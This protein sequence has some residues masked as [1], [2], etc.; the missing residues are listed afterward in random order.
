MNKR[1]II[2]LVPTA[3]DKAI[4]A[5]GWALLALLWVFTV[6]AY[7]NMPDII[8]AH[9]D[10]NGEVNARG[11]KST[12][13][14]IPILASVTFLMLTL[15]NKYPHLFNYTVQITEENAVYQ[16]TMATRLL[17]VVNVMV[18]VVFLIISGLIY[19]IAKGVMENTGT[20][21]IIVVTLLPIMPV[22]WY[23]IKLKRKPKQ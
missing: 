11:N 20:F 15:L 1:P 7:I 19:A 18:I 16:Y 22:V 6:Y 2:K 21:V 23:F 4:Q 10:A 8:P 5:T 17:R 9:F 12:I 13:W 14:I 3:T